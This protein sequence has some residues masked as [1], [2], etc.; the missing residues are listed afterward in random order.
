MF[1]G[2]HYGVEVIVNYLDPEEDVL[3]QAIKS[4]DHAN[5]KYELLPIDVCLPDSHVPVFVFKYWKDGKEKFSIFNE[6]K[7][8]YYIT[9]KLPADIDIIDLIFDVNSQMEHGDEPHNMKSLFEKLFRRAQIEALNYVYYSE[10]TEEDKMC[11]DSY[12]EIAKKEHILSSSE[13]DGDDF[14]EDI[15][16]EDIKNED[17]SNS[18]KSMLINKIIADIL[19]R[20]G[21]NFHD[22]KMIGDIDH[23]DKIYKDGGYEFTLL[24]LF[25][26]YNWDETIK[27]V[28][29]YTEYKG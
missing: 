18:A 3:I 7:N 13:F 25:N 6:E 1:I 24:K 17:V 20:K 27:N 9:E 14:G 11:L 21:Y 23:H 10:L 29:L 26:G 12:M 16:D 22:L 28:K 4:F 2:S 19:R 8:L 5:I 15:A